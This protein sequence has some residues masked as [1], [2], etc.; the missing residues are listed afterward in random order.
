MLSASSDSVSVL[1][2]ALK[3]RRNIRVLSAPK[4]H[5]LDN[6]QAQIQAGQFVP[7]VNGVIVS[8]LNSVPQIVYQETGLILS[9]TPRIT[10]EGEVVMGVSAQKSALSGATVPI[11]FDTNSGNT[12]NS[13]I[14]NQTIATTTVMVND[15]Q[16]VVL[17][18][19]IIDSDTVNERKVPYF[20]DLPYIGHAF[21]YDSNVHMR[22]E[23]LIFLTPHIVNNDA[24]FELVKQVE[25]ERHQLLRA[26]CGTDQRSVVLGAASTAGNH[27][28]RTVRD[29]RPPDGAARRRDHP[30]ADRR[31]APVGTG[32]DT[33]GP[34]PARSRSCLTS[35][36][37]SDRGR[38]PDAALKHCEHADSRATNV[39]VSKQ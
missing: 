2:R 37:R 38:R 19:I 4:V 6:Q 22:S 20:G 30:L 31:T 12:I 15:G 36:S 7:L 32:T 10:P 26:R 9:V 17:G 5:A 28:Q 24:D 39:E 11:F 1:L 14:I 8:G 3:A 18:G 29:D 27:L 13:P 35:E 21:R 23:L 33:D 34:H 25:T 16:S